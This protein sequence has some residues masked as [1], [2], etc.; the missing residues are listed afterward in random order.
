MAT[1]QE[2]LDS[3]RIYS[4]LKKVVSDLVQNYGCDD[5]AMKMEFCVESE[6]FEVTFKLSVHPNSQLLTL[7]S[8]LNFTVAEEY[9][10]A[11]AR[12]ICELNYDRMYEA[13]FDFSP[14]KGFTVFRVPILFRKSIIS[15]ELIDKAVRYTF[16]IVN[17]YTP[18]LYDLSHGVEAVMPEE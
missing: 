7:Y 16:A 4:T 2:E 14:T 1:T 18:Y 17:K 8:K 15:P 13:T 12:A 9:R 3:K 6:P 11:Y 10:D 5:D